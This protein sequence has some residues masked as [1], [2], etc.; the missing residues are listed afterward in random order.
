MDLTPY[1][2]IFKNYLLDVP[3]E[4]VFNRRFQ[5][6]MDEAEYPGQIID[7]INRCD[8]PFFREA[9]SN[10]A[11]RYVLSHTATRADEDSH[12]L[13]EDAR[14][15]ITYQLEKIISV[16]RGQ[17]KAQNATFAAGG[18]LRQSDDHEC[19]IVKNEQD[20]A[21][22]SRDLDQ[23][24]EVVSSIQQPHPVSALPPENDYTFL[25]EWLEKEKRLGRDYYREANFNR[26]LMCRRLG[27]IINWEPDPRTLA[28]NQRRAED[29]RY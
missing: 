8:C 10:C 19:R 12:H 15:E 18:S 22:L 21:R 2:A 6:Y 5:I 1:S 13:S 4:E 20:I 26:S 28:R 7:Q 3:S 16:A 23:L 29:A 27:N 11:Y 17:Q 25:N 9:Y 24:K 14:R